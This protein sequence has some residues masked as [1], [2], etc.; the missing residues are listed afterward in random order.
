[1]HFK[2]KHQS[3][4][5]NIALLQ[6]KRQNA[7]KK[8]GEGRIMAPFPGTRWD[9]YSPVKVMF[10]FPLEVFALRDRGEFTAL[11]ERMAVEVT[12]VMP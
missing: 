1:M 2:S 10:T 9:Q 6:K 5:T 3:F 12:A 7:N 4:W 11:S 8:A